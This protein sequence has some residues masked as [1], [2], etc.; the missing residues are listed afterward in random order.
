[1]LSLACVF[2]RDGLPS[3]KMWFDC[4]EDRCCGLSKV[5]VVETVEFCQVMWFVMLKS[6]KDRILGLDTQDNN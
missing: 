1:M 2:V 6:G 4:G 5:G 3:V